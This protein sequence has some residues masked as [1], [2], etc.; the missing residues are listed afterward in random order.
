[1]N[2]K[3]KIYGYIGGRK[4]FE[5]KMSTDDVDNLERERNEMRA[6]IMKAAPMLSAAACV[7]IEEAIDRF[8]EIE[9]VRGVL[10][11]CPVDFN[12]DKA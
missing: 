1:M 11:L 12:I 10:E 7:V 8:G 9:G 6:W 5:L 2:Y 3:G 4:Y